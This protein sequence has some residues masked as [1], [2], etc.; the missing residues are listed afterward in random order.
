MEK[1]KVDCPTC[2]GKGT[3]RK[4]WNSY[5]VIRRYLNASPDY[6]YINYY[7]EQVCPRCKGK[8]KVKK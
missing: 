2:E 3:W 5:G 1:N 6:G 7:E 4:K 8:G